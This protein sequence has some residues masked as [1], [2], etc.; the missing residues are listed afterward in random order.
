MA[1]P[2]HDKEGKFASG[3]GAG[4]ISGGGAM[5]RARSLHAEDTLPQL[6][7]NEVGY[8]T[9]KLSPDMKFSVGT[10][11]YGDRVR[12]IDSGSY[13]VHD[14]AN[15]GLAWEKRAGIVAKA[16]RNSGFAVTQSS[17]TTTHIQGA[18][19]TT[20]LVH[21]R[22][23]GK[24][25]SAILPSGKVITNPR[26]GDVLLGSGLISQWAGPKIR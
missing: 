3:P 19:G 13:D 18:G 14:V 22:G 15:S 23:Q 12:R 7:T 21:A 24:I 6:S 16:A 9:G 26:V 25:A 1:N 10:K 2:N 8:M 17:P 4:R 5:A 20:V 11:E